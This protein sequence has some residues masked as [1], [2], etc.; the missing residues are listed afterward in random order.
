MP[1]SWVIDASVAAKWY[2]R[3]EANLE[4][5]DA[6]Q[7]AHDRGDVVLTAPRFFSYEV[8]AV[9]RNAI[10]ARHITPADAARFS[11]QFVA[12]E[13]VT[14]PE[15]ESDL[16]LL[17]A[18]R[19]SLRYGCSFYDALYLELAEELGWRF[20]TAERRLTQLLARRAPYLVELRNYQA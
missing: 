20:L 13:F 15:S 4:Q 6:V 10:A 14:A 5:A 3:D 16:F 8:L 7:N 17:R 18:H 2:L 11:Q 1:E 12:S 9:I 19:L